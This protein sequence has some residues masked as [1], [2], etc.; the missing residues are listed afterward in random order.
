MLN[1]A[2]RDLWWR[3]RRYLVS[4][5]GCGL[6]FATSLLMSGLAA[7]FTSELDNTIASF[8]AQ[9]FLVPDGTT[10]P[11]T[12]AKPFPRSVLPA[13]VA[14][15]T[16]MIQM[17]DPA[18]PKAVVLFGVERGGGNEPK[19]ISGH[20][21]QNDNQALVYDSSPFDTGSHILIG[22][23]SYLVVGRVDHFTMNVGSPG[24]AV[25]VTQVQHDLLAGA[26]IVTGG[27]VTHAGVRAPA[28]YHIVSNGSARDDA[29]RVLGPAR[30]AINS[31]KVLLWVVAALIVGS[32]LFLAAIER[33]KEFAVFKA[34]GTPTAG[35]AAG[36]MLQ[37]VVLAVLA[38]VIAI[39]VALAAQPAFPIPVAIP[40]SS[41]VALPLLAIV[42]GCAGGG[43]GLRRAVGVDPALAFG[44]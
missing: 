11:F 10:G 9:G 31:I 4:I 42:V 5:I 22:G 1:A 43:F 24:V 17:A 13:G 41:L 44:G 21:L 18:Q 30:Q 38:S 32:V 3:R 29:L 33:T 34:I 25:S 12:G 2:L 14:P 16:F 37:G 20:Q 7:S 6:V 23:H 35:L 40:A 39:A 26:D 8:H 15:F 28:G 19:V 27:V 36:L